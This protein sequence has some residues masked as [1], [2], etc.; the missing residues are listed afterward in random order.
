M[1]E[2]RYII[3][4]SEDHI[5]TITLNRPEVHNAIHIEM[6][7]EISDAFSRLSKKKN[8]RLIVIRSNG[9]NFSAGADLKWM[10]KGLEQ[11]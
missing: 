2:Y 10:K 3:A 4:S 9:E 11:S 5:G 1:K 8:L 7:R 6:I